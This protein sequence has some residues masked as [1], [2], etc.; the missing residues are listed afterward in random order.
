MQNMPNTGAPGGG[1]MDYNGNPLGG[2]MG[3][4]YNSAGPSDNNNYG[5]P[6]VPR[7]DL[8]PGIG[9]GVGLPQPQQPGLPTDG[10]GGGKSMGGI[11][12]ML[13]GII[14]GQLPQDAFG[15]LVGNVPT[16]MTP[17]MQSA[18]FPNQQ[19]PIT[20]G[21]G[22]LP[23]GFGAPSPV[24]RSQIG[25]GAQLIGGPAG[26]PIM[27]PPVNRFAPPNAPGVRSQRGVPVQQARTVNPRPASRTR[28]R[29][30]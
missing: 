5:G 17:P 14:G 28:S 2:G 20:Q 27:N 10:M 25:P 9:F 18:Q 3:T 21:N 13:P 12:G 1:G 29:M 15:Q 19:Q 30:G 16:P 26:R 11:G 23:P 6:Y 8:G 24:D 7:P 22:Q 4:Q